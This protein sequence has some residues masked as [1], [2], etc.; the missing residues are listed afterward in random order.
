M[1]RREFIKVFGSAAAWPLA[2]SA[3]QLPM[4]DNV[5]NG[6][7]AARDMN[8]DSADLIV[9]GGTILTQDPSAPSAEALAVKGERVLAVGAANDIAALRGPQTRSI[10]LDG[11]TV[12]PGL[13]DAHAHLEREGLKGQRLS[14]K[15]LRSIGDILNAIRAAAA[16]AQPGEWVVTMPVGDPPYFFGGTAVLGERRMPTRHELDGVAPD[17][18]VY[19]AGSFNNWGEPPGYS[20]LNSLAL[21]KNGITGATV[22]A[23]P[24]VEIIKDANGEPTGVIIETNDR[25]TVE[26]DLLSAV[27]K[28]GW[29]GRLD[30]IR[31]SMKL[32]NAVGTTSAYE[33]HGSS[34][35]TLALYRNLWEGGELSVRMSLVV[36]PTWTSSAQAMRDLR[37]LLP[38]A[39]GQ[40]FGD[41]WLRVSGVF[42][43]L[44]GNI[45]VRSAAMAALPDTG[46]S[47]FVEHANSWSEYRDYV[48]AAAELGFRVHTIGSANLDKLL[49]IWAEADDRFGIKDKRWVLEHVAIVNSAEVAMIKRL[50]VHVTSIPSKTFWK[51][52]PKLASTYQGAAEFVT[53]YRTFVNEGIPIAFGTD[54][55]PISQFF[56]LWNATTRECRN[57]EI[58]GPGQRLT[59]TDAL[60]LVTREGAKLSF[61]EHRKGML[62]AGMLAD[63]AVLDGD[64][65]STPSDRIKNASASTT[66]VGGRIV[67]E[68]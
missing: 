53:P 48:M 51:R 10:A 41:H 36:S 19:I 32:Y 16:R 35:E 63:F 2:A 23:C 42:I 49:S 57:G 4:S 33:G 55:V 7:F 8:R 39:R 17:N 54:N 12:L 67:H 37:D 56:P 6:R 60:P 14:L 21:R 3:Q 31:T 40:G 62:R 11:R 50:G 46:W 5:A 29:Q 15:G 38:Y 1:R 9:S 25:P 26:F 44:N 52:G 27:P 65:L 45:A 58:V 34:A 20:A 28:F 18:P 61:D 68:S 59:L 43:G 22:P 47:G 13:I 66:V 30:A 24:G 64:L